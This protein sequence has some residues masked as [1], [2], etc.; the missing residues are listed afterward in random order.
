[1][2][3]RSL[4]VIGTLLLLLYVGAYAGLSRRGYAEAH[5]DHL[6][7]FYY[8]PPKDSGAWRVVNYG[9]VLLFY[10]LNALDRWLGFGLP[11][12]CEPLWGLSTGPAAGNLAG[13]ACGTAG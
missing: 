7:G 1:M 8:F 5:R 6:A 10:P 9:C 11:P 4:T 12:A 3:K 13:P 2:R